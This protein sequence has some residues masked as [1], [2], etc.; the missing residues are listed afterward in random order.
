MIRRS[1]MLGAM[2]LATSTPL[3]AEEDGFV[4]FKVLKP[5][6]AI[7][8]ATAAMEN[9]RDGGYQV[10]VA[11]VDRFGGLQ[12]FVRDRYAGPHTSET[13]IRKAWTAVSFRTNTT[14]LDLV[15]R[16]GGASAGI[17]SISKALP[18]GGGV[19]VENAGTIVAGIGVSGA[20]GPEID[21][22]CAKAGIE[23]IEDVLGF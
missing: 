22:Q 13:A 8:M 20:P 19:I 6:H 21:E 3:L 16:P 10:G 2:M 23:A 9:C 1:A 7:T 4:T 18:L 12:T 17:R 14:D 5:E 11:V 15:T